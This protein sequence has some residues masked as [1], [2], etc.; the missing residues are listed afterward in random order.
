MD[1]IKENI[2]KSAIIIADLT[3]NNANVYYELGMAHTYNK[4]V[5]LLKQR[6]S[7]LLFDIQHIRVVSYDKDNET[8]LK[9]RLTEEIKYFKYRK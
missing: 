7:K 8:D 1:R 5:I 3:N 9:K 4:N 2:Q 6:D